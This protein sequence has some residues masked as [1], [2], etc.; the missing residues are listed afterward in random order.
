VIALTIPW[1][2][3]IGRL[4]SIKESI[5]SYDPDGVFPWCLPEVA[6]PK[7][8]LDQ[9]ERALGVSLP[10]EL[11]AFLS[12]ADGWRGVLVRADLFGSEDLVSKG[13]ALLEREDVVRFLEKVAI[14][15]QEVL[16]I[17]ASD[18]EKTMFLLRLDS[19]HIG[20]IIWY[21]EEEIECFP[22]FRSFFSCVTEHNV[23]L[24][25]EVRSGRWSI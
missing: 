5:A 24:L 8:K 10:V 4:I 9:V 15:A 18:T 13:K 2:A 6:A 3:E 21:D 19:S 7:E 1:N 20:Q 23:E 11:K 12:H 17:G 22:S 16:V 14:N 25:G